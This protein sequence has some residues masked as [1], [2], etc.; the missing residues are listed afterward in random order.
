[1]N[2][3]CF[4]TSKVR[5]VNQW[6]SNFV[7]EP[8]T[9]PEKNSP[10]ALCLE[11]GMLYRT[12][13]GHQVRVYAIGAGGSFPVHGAILLDNGKW[14]HNSFTSEGFYSST[15]NPNDIVER[16][17]PKLCI[18]WQVLP[19]WANYVAQD[20]TGSWFWF[21]GHPKAGQRAWDAPNSARGCVPQNYSGGWNVDGIPWRETLSRR[22]EISSF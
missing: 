7:K 5:T 19:A 20:E 10:P 11:P 14:R 15:T 8:A 1:M 2:K 13:D 4:L 6:H 21:T 17:G 3:I 18:D 12:R 9:R 16:W 22:P